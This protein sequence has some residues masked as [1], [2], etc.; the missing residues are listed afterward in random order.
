MSV[1]GQFSGL[2]MPVFTAFGWAGEENAIKFAL[3]ELE[4][5]INTVYQDLSQEA[6]GEFAHFGINPEANTA[7]LAG[8]RETEK[9]VYVAFN[10]RPLTFEM[11]FSVR[12]KAVLNRGLRA[13]EKNPILW[14]RLISELGEGW[15]LHIQQ[16]LIDEEGGE[17]SFYQDIFK[18]DVVR[19]T[20]EV[21]ETITSR[22]AFLNSEVKWVTPFHISYRIPSDQV[23]GMKEEIISF[24]C[25]KIDQL[26]PILQNFTK[27]GASKK[28][29]TRKTTKRAT[30]AKVASPKAAKSKTAAGPS[31]NGFTY[32]ADLKPL[33]IRKGFINLT[34]DHWPFFATSA[35]SELREIT[36]YFD[37][38]FDKD[39]A[40]WRLQ[41]NDL[42]RIVLSDDA[43]RWLENEF[44]SETKIKVQATRLPSEEI[45]INLSPI[46][47]AA[48][49]EVAEPE[50]DVS[51]AEAAE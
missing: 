5:F 18:D 4:L 21:A 25:E 26:L 13:G 20:P 22:A 32:E 37:G 50:A 34:T 48:E 2:A 30:K 19:L 10:A 40:V 44:S 6:R 3:A 29:K 36:V 51:E 49:T 35:R 38:K 17:A 46:V 1:N 15:S 39:C 47:D 8:K 23:A 7:Y 28:P 43:H 45:Q 9:G 42:A 27:N 31:R 12:D 33:H 24:I 41:P 16:Y 11:R 14:H